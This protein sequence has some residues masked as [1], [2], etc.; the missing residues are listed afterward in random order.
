M[1]AGSTLADPTGVGGVV[2]LAPSLPPSL[3]GPARAAMDLCARLMPAVPAPLKKAPPADLTRLPEQRRSTALDPLIHNGRVPLKLAA[4]ALHVAA[5]VWE[6]APHHWHTPCLLV[7]GTA[8]TSTDHGQSRRLAALLPTADKTLHLV[9]GGQH[10]SCTTSTVTTYSPGCC[11]GWTPTPR[12]TPRRRPLRQATPR[13]SAP[14]RP[15]RRFT[16]P[17]R[18]RLH[19]GGGCS[20]PTAADIR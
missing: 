12:H 10:D 6:R 4:T 19:N 13:A 9:A 1:T 15:G 17:F 16:D 14:A 20:R 8:D 7:H 18:R 3:P 5:D 2:L 11:R